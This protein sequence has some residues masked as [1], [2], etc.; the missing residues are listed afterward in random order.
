MGVDSV[1]KC[2]WASEPRV[3]QACLQLWAVLSQRDVQ[4]DHYSFEELSSYAGSDDDSLMSRVV[5]YFASPK[6]KIIRLCI[7]YESEGCWV[8][9]PDEEVERYSS[10]ESV[11]HPEL[12]VVIDDSDLIVCFV[13]GDAL[14]SGGA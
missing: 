7:M 14:F 3:L 2:D 12:G 13:P 8:A 6:L 5:L 11:V 1:I 10:G 4:L 9:L